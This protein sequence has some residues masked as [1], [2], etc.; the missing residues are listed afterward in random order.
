M[1]VGLIARA[2]FTGLGIQTYDFYKHMHPDKVLVID[3]QHLNGQKT[4]LGQYPGA[5]ILRYTPYPD[6]TKSHPSAVGAIN[7]FL[8]DLDLVFTCETPYDYHLFTEAR[9]RGVRSVLQYNFELMDHVREPQLPQPDLFMAPSLWRYNE[10]QVQNKV[11]CPVPVDRKRFVPELRTE[12]RTFVHVG[13]TP[14]LEDRN[15]TETV[16]QAWH[17]VQGE[18]PLIVYTQMGNYSNRDRRVD[19]RRGT[20]PDQMEFYNAGDVLLLPRKFGG[21]CLP[22]NEAMS[23]AMP[24]IMTDL[25]PQNA[26]LSPRGMIPA[27]HSKQVMTKMMVDV[28]EP[29]I[30][31]LGAKVNELVNN[32]ELVLELSMHSDRVA[33]QISWEKLEPVYRRIFEAVVEGRVPEQEFY[34]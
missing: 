5:E 11:F 20:I 12:A 25:G 14:A 15:G 28:Y 3:L 17:M 8:D 26:F 10:V 29:D 30:A 23:C 7:A 19:I 18:V 1:R 24:V 34:W 31:A 22:L 16:I 4:D 6:T 13:G 32:P 2:D 9:A 33:Y 21:L 27:R